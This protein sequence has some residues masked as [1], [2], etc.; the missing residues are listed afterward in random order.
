MIGVTGVIF[1]FIPETP[2]WLASKGKLEEAAKVLKI[3]NGHVPGYD[4]DEQIV[5]PP[6]LALI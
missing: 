2:W 5:S 4:I 6:F 3:C 1:A